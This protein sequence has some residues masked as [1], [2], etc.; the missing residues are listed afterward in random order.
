[1]CYNEQKI[2][3]LGNKVLYYIKIVLCCFV[4]LNLAVLAVYR[5][6]ADL[7]RSWLHFL[8]DVLYKENW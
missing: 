8:Q 5:F 3:K 7:Q 1:M 4:L 2:G 6:Q